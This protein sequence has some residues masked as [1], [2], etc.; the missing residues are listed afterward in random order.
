MRGILFME[1]RYAR[2][3]DLYRCGSREPGFYQNNSTVLEHAGDI[4]AMNG[5]V[6]EAVGYWKQALDDDHQT[7]ILKWKIENKQYITEEDPTKRTCSC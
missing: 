1:E 7:E 2:C 4:Y 5:M 6:N 3:Q